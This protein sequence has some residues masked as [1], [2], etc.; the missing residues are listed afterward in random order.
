MSDDNGFVERPTHVA[1]RASS[2]TSPLRETA[3]NGKAIVVNGHNASDR[4]ALLRAGFRLHV[5]KQTDGTFLA[6]CERIEAPAP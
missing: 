3:D 1:V 2:I 4:T 6:W 5:R